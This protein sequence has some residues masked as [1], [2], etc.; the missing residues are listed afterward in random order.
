MDLAT[1]LARRASQT[2]PRYRDRCANCRKI[3][4]T[5]YCATLRPFHSPVDFVIL[6]HEA[7]AR[8][9]IATARMAHLSIRN[10][11]LIVGRSFHDHAL[12]NRMIAS[13]LQ[14]NVMLFPSEG[15][16]PI[17]DLFAA[18]QHLDPRPLVFWVLDAKWAQV[19]KMLRLSPNLRQIPM[20]KFKPESTSR[21]QLRHQPEPTY[22]S[23]LES[24]HLVID[25][26]LQCTGQQSD[27]HHAL[28]D[29]FQAFV[30]QQLDF[31]DPTRATRHQVAK[32][33]RRARRDMQSATTG[34]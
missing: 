34:R 2:P 21:F 12:V 32:A 7:E 29:V 3:V 10:S 30:R 8:N 13:P 20:V 19:P 16:M 25:R 4:S 24:I 14:R 17:E 5:C 31:V 6:Q 23:T 33:L 22:L 9:A 15:A 27:D 1:F 26:F 28:L 18:P 11:Q